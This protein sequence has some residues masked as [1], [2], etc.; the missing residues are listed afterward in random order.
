[1]KFKNGVEIS[2]QWGYGNFCSNRDLRKNYLSPMENE[3]NE[4]ETAE[5]L[6]TNQR[7]NITHE[8]ADFINAKGDGHVVGWLNTDQVSDAISW[9]KN[10]K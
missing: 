2:V 5:V 8:F 1:M 6:I 10:Y 9:A 7:D 4:S 3:F